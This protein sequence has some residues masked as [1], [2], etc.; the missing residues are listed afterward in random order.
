MLKEDVFENIK[1]QLKKYKHYSLEYTEYVGISNYDVICS[2]NEIILIF[3][4]N[5][6]ADL[7]EFHWAAN[8]ALILIK[9][10]NQIKKD[11]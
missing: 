11:L 1:E 4:Y 2:N 6:E 5:K 8:D 9:E 3:G 10:I 7:H